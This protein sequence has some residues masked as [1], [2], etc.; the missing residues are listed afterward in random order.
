MNTATLH[1]PASAPGPHAA[2]APAPSSKPRVL[3]VDDEGPI[4][5]IAEAILATIGFESTLVPSGEAALESYQAARQGGRPYALVLMDLALPGGMSGLETADRLRHLDSGVK[6]IISSG[7]L[8]PN[9][10]AAALESGFAGILPKPYSVER[11]TSEVRWAL[12][13]P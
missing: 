13:R 12:A 4:C 5:R 8:E 7:Y 11:M 6:I 9:A 3:V 2:N 1:P 10:R